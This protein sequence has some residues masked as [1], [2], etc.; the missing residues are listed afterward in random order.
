MLNLYINGEP[1]DISSEDEIIFTSTNFR[2]LSELREIFSTDFEIPKTIHNLTLLNYTSIIDYLGQPLAHKIKGVLFMGENMMDVDI[3][4]VEVTEERIKICI[5]EGILPERIRNLK[6]NQTLP[7]NQNWIKLFNGGTTFSTTNDFHLYDYGVSYIPTKAQCHPSIPLDSLKN[8]LNQSIHPYHINFPQNDNYMVCSGLKVSPYNHKQIIEVALGENGQCKLSGGQHITNDLT[9]TEEGTDVIT[10][11][12][13]CNVSMTIWLYF[14][15]KN[16]NAEGEFRLALDN[17]TW[18]YER[19]YQSIGTSVS[20]IGGAL[21]VYGYTVPSNYIRAGVKMSCSVFNYDLFKAFGAVIEMNITDY[22]YDET[23]FNTEMKYVGRYPKISTL[24]WSGEGDEYHNVVFDG[25]EDYYNT[26]YH[27]E[28][29]PIP[30]VKLSFCYYDMVTNV[31]SCTIAELLYNLQFL[32]GKKLKLDGYDITYVDINNAA[33][34]DPDHTIVNSYTLASTNLGK[35]NYV[36]YEGEDEENTQPF[37]TI[38]NDWLEDVVVLHKSKLMKCN[39]TNN[40]VNITQYSRDN[41]G[42]YSFEG[43]IES[44]IICKKFDSSNHLICDGLSAIGYENLKKAVEVN[45]T[46]L[47]DC[48]NCDYVNLNG[49][50]YM[51][52][53]CEYDPAHNQSD[54]NTL[55]V[56]Y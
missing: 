27:Q 42:S 7:E 30:T 11:N 24:N 31:T 49:H 39:S 56:N 1:L 15:N 18:N 50:Q 22:D 32:W 28:N 33:E 45:F 6:I 25:E 16:D 55:L 51:V 52:V 46:T 29:I 10:F 48:I 13:S 3:Q 41:D 4:V 23:D 43:D 38:D 5:F 53:E 8:A 47:G 40:R 14:H 12:R 21:Y 17:N 44:L 37:S 34:L 2:F 9:W 20:N 36:L 35:K 26:V 19:W 54:I